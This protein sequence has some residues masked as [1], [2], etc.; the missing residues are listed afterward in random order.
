[1]K[2]SLLK[3]IPLLIMLL[4]G[5]TEDPSSKPDD[6]NNPDT[7]QLTLSVAELNYSDGGGGQSVV[8]RSN[9]S[10]TVS[11]TND[12]CTVDHIDGSYDGEITATAQPNAGYDDRSV[13]LTVK[14]GNITRILTINQR[15]KDALTLTQGRYEIKQEGGVIAVE[16]KH[17]LDF[18]V[19]IP[20]EFATWIISVATK[21][22]AT[23]SLQFDIAANPGYDPREVGSSSGTVTVR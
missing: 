12:W 10:W 13:N 21:G 20:Q 6:P 22:L 7:P 2:V 3:S 14:A 5:C 23:S 17:N 16:V 9:A 4:V 18:T 8:I 15:K 11:G 1:M 19:S